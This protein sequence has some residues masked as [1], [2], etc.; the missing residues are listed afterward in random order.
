MPTSVAAPDGWQ[1]EITPKTISSIQPGEK[2]VISIRI[3]PP[4]NIVASEY[5]ITIR[6]SSDQTDKSDEFHIVVKE[7]SLAAVFGVLILV[8]VGGGVYYMFRKYK[9]R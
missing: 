2:Q 9:R 7:Q 8:L 3:V 1:A 6:V 5:K 4:A